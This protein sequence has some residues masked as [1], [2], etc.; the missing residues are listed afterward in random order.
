MNAQKQHM[1]S[2][3]VRAWVN[4]EPIPWPFKKVK[5]NDGRWHERDYGKTYVYRK[6]KKFIFVFSPSGFIQGRSVMTLITI[7][8][9]YEEE[10]NNNQ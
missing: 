3:A 6:Y 2:I 8:G 5:M 7:R 10:K 1:A 9:P 4:E